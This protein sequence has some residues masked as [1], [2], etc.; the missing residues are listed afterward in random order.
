MVSVKASERQSEVGAHALASEVQVTRGEHSTPAGAEAGAGAG[1]EA[2]AEQKHVEARR[3]KH[4]ERCTDRRS[5]D[6]AGCWR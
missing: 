4:G 5:R 1:A 6:Y 2:D 3:S